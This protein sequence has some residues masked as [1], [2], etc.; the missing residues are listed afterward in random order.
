MTAR[1]RLPSLALAAAA[2]LCAC[3]VEVDVESPPQDQ[4]IPVTSFATPVYAEVAIDIPEEARSAAELV[5]V[6]L[7]R[8]TGQVVNPGARS[9][10]ALSL[11]LSTEGTAQ[12]GTPKLYTN[13]DKPAYVDRATVLVPEQ[14]FQPGTTTPIRVDSTQAPALR[15]VLSEERI[16]IIVSNTLTSTGVFPVD[17]LPY[18]LQL[19]DL[20]FRAEVEKRFEGI[21]GAQGVF[22]L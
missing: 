8:V 21:T 7:V 13:L 9:R 11:R 20:V 16:Y 4:S 17:P 3:G 6:N 22:G 18:N 1:T 12:P 14:V 2:L 15:T 19:E 10:L 5:T